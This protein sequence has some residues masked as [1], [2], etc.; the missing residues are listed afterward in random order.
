MCWGGHGEVEDQDELVDQDE[1]EGQ[2][3][4]VCVTYKVSME[5]SGEYYITVVLLIKQSVRD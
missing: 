5:K 1:V 4:P 2:G 3:E